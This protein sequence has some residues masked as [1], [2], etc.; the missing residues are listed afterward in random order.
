MSLPTANLTE[1]RSPVCQ[2]PPA[3]A[4]FTGR[5]PQAARLAQILSGDRDNRVG[6]PVVV[7][8]GLPGVGKTTLALQVAHTLRPEFPD[9]QLWVP[10]QGG[11]G[12]PR[13][14]AEVL[15][16][17]DRAGRAWSCHPKLRRRAVCAVPVGAG[18]AAGPRAGRRRRDGHPK[19]S[20]CCPAPASARSWL[21]AAANSPGHPGSHLIVL[22]PLAPA[23]AIGPA[24]PD[25]GK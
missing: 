10:L 12:H 23:E 22:D 15:G 11:S 24:G 25:P 14:P 8:V 20:R 7:I 6:V 9:G 4:D 13:D 16:G 2:L 17:L 21:P 1:P 18:R 19:S 5:Q 3:V